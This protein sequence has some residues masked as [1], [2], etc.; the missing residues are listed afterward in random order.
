MKRKLR[1]SLSWLLTVAMIFSLVFGA[2]PTASAVGSEGITDITG[3]GVYDGIGNV[4]F[5]LYTTDAYK[6]LKLADPT[7]TADTTINSVTLL[8]KEEYSGNNH[9]TLVGGLGTK[10]PTNYFT[11]SIT[12][13]NGK[14]NPSNITGIEITYDGEKTVTI[15]ASDLRLESDIVTTPGVEW[16]AVYE[17]KSRH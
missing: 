6:L 14:A 4:E 1:K 17:I 2:I 5:R 10:I 16:N 13:T 15:Q 8:L 12:N 9:F 11:N 3:E 7:I